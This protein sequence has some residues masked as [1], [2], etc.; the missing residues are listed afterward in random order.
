[1]ICQATEATN[2]QILFQL[3]MYKIV[4]LV[5]VWLCNAAGLCARLPN[6][7]NLPSLLQGR[8]IAKQTLHNLHCTQVAL[9][10][11]RCSR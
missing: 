7:Y 1:M 5:Q 11:V 9:G 6:V 4:C 10:A 8:G 2:V 3:H